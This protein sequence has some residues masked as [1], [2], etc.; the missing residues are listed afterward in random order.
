MA[1]GF[2]VGS[3]KAGE[4][5]ES[6][7][8][9]IVRERATRPRREWDLL[10]RSRKDGDGV[11]GE[12]VKEYPEVFGVSSLLVD[13]KGLRELDTAVE[14]RRE[15][16]DWEAMNPTSGV[17]A[18]ENPTKSPPSTLST[19]TQIYLQITSEILGP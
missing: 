18:R 16:D 14:S 6:R 2:G 4:A 11:V 9:G 8:M 10:L 19:R 3:V 1:S 5:D 12:G 13:T 7:S 15:G 17:P